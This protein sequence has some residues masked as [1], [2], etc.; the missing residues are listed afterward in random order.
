MLRHEKAFFSDATVVV[1]V[2]ACIYAI[3]NPNIS[4]ALSW[5]IFVVVAIY[6]ALQTR[7]VFNLWKEYKAIK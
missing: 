1:L 3:K 2:F 7:H 5:T 6:V 4:P